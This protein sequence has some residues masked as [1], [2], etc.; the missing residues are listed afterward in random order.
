M[1]ALA[2]APHPA[3]RVGRGLLTAVAAVF[4]TLGFVLGVLWLAASWP[5]LA[6]LVGWREATVRR[7]GTRT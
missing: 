5:V 4:Y 2:A 6:A 1:T 3:V 7:G